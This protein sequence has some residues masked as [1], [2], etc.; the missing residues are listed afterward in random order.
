[1]CLKDKKIRINYVKKEFRNLTFL[2]LVNNSSLEGV[3][4][5]ALNKKFLNKNKNFFKTQVKNRCVVSLR[6]RSPLRSFH[7]SRV[8][9]RAQASAGLMLGVKKSS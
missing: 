2:F 6:S 9:F 1:M 7:L 3:Y 4:K 8:S 5:F